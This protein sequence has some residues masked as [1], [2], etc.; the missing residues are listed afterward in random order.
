MTA[1]VFEIFM[2]QHPPAGN[3]VAAANAAL[4]ERAAL[5]PFIKERMRIASAEAIGCS[6]CARVRTELDGKTIVEREDSLREDDLAKAELA[7]QFIRA[8]V[9]SRGE[10]CD[11]L[12]M[13]LQ[14]HYS[15]A[16]F[17]DLVF[18]LGWFIGMQHVGRFMHWDQACPVA[19]M[20]ELVE[21]GQAA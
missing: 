12:T 5:S 16:E 4:W 2:S 13:E 8:V 7:E 18:S 21:A 15:P 17:A 10:I 6:Y 11:K 9:E 20:R 19:Q 14:R 1:N 3:A